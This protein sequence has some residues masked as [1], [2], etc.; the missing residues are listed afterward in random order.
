MQ[1]A[2]L[3][4]SGSANKQ[5]KAGKI[6]GEETEGS[7]DAAAS[8]WGSHLPAKVSFFNKEPPAGSAG[9]GTKAAAKWANTSS[10]WGIQQNTFVRVRLQ[11]R[12]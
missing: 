7:S 6:A 4:S 1:K 8:T 10:L 12:P 3:I 11:N 9:P 2:D 5:K